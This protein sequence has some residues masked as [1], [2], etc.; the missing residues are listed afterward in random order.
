MTAEKLPEALPNVAMHAAQN[1]LA[2]ELLAARHV[3]V[4]PLATHSKE[5]MI[6]ALEPLT[7]FPKPPR[8]TPPPGPLIVL[9]APP[10]HTDTPGMTVLATPLCT[11]AAGST[12]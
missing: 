10:R 2:V 8:Q 4:V 9:S 12:V 3:E 7:V 11:L 6:D 5:P 1:P